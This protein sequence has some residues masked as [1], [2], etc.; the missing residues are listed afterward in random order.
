MRDFVEGENKREK[1]K[2]EERRGE[3]RKGEER[4]K[5]DF[6]VILSLFQNLM[7]LLFCRINVR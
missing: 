7:K 3:E 2:G 1:S 6:E 5:I 4:K